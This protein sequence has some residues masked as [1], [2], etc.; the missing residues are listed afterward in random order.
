MSDNTIFEYSS[1]LPGTSMINRV[2]DAVVLVA[3]LS[4]TSISRYL[5]CSP[6]NTDTV[7]VTE[8]R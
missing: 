7:F 6:A 2:D 8:K 5:V 4:T 1:I 3:V